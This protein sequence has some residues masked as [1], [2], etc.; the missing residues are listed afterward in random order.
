MSQLMEDRRLM[1][2]EHE[3]YKTRESEKY[4]LLEQRL[5]KTQELLRDTTKD[6]LQVS[7][8]ALMGCAQNVRTKHLI[9]K[10]RRENVKEK[11][12]ESGYKTGTN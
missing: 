5:R 6:F 8:Q 11:R 7:V 12:N 2:D 4:E 10:F 9:V 1:T 3:T